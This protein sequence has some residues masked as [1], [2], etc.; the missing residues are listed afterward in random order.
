MKKVSILVLLEVPLQPFG[1][2]Q[3]SVSIVMFQSLCSSMFQSLF[4]WKYLFNSLTVLV[5]LLKVL[6]QSLFYWKYLFNKRLEK[7]FNPCFTGSTSSTI[8]LLSFFGSFFSF[9]PCFTG[10]TSSTLK[11]FFKLLLTTL[12]FNPCFT[13]STSSTPARAILRSPLRRRFNPCF[14]GSTS[15][16]TA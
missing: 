3:Y 9:N 5:R 1:S 6:F 16:T 7:S 11:I 10:S 15:S 8:G 14:T 4:Y 2:Q 12:S 13:G